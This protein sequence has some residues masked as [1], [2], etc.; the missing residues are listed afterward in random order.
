MARLR[1]LGRSER[2]AP[3]SPLPGGNR[4]VRGAAV[5][6]S[7]SLLQ[8]AVSFLLLPLYARVLTPTEYGELGIIVT[9]AAAAG[10][11]LGFGL[12][13]AVFR[14]LI[15]L[16]DEPGERGRYL[17]AVGGFSL[18][19]PPVLALIISGPIGLAAQAAFQVP[20]TSVAIGIVG[21]GL[22]A[23][24]AIV[25]F[26][27]LRAEE[28]LGDYLRVTTVQAV[29]GITLPLLF[30]VVFGWGVPGWLLASAITTAIVVTW[31]SALVGHGWSRHVRWTYVWSALAFGLPIIPHALSH[32]G[33]AISDRAILGFYVSSA[34]VG[35][36]FMAYQLTI[37]IT[38][39]SIALSQSVQPLFALAATKV[40][41]RSELRRILTYQALGVGFV[42]MATVVLGPA[43]IV[44]ALPS[45]YVGATVLLPWIAI[46]A[47]LFGLYLIPM[48]AV[49]LTAGRSRWVWL[50][51]LSAALTNI[52]LNLVLV[53][54][55]GTQAAAIDTVLGYAVLLVGVFAYMLIVSKEPLTF[56]W[57][58]IGAGFLLF[59][60]VIVIANLTAPAG[61]DVAGLVVR[62]VA[63]GAVGIALS[64]TGLLPR[65]GRPHRSP[66]APDT[67]AS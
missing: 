53:P 32:W 41:I 60:A 29:V 57:E 50:V 67:P 40:E 20:A 61:A 13:T 22:S 21:A 36:Y 66:A 52:A 6:G 25:P 31:G 1:V 18:V 4:A 9:I 62:V 45:S 55:F 2:S 58:R 23:S 3:R 63:V 24:A 33:L 10:A 14:S 59:A 26:A 56:E 39:L 38:V 16:A 30:V 34:D 44:L 27:V 64:M 28:R 37:P 8:R 49:T 5:Y 17:N 35:V 11:I 65:V 7:A 43:A 48:N 47:G 19:V 46:G 54:R 15:T 42:V 51:T 12:E